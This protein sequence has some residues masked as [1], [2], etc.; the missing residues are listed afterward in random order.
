MRDGYSLRASEE[1]CVRRARCA[2]P[3]AVLRCL[4][5]VAADVDGDIDGIEER[6]RHASAIVERRR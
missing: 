6:A 5:D 4:Y 2:M 3:R 1:R